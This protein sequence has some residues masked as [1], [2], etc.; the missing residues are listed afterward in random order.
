[1]IQPIIPTDYQLAGA[2][3]IAVDVQARTSKAPRKL[4]KWQR[5][6]KVKKNQIKFK[7]GK[8]NLK[9]M[10]RAYRRRNK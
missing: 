8:L 9:A 4:S 2:E 6:M 5:Y 1:V 10:G 3:V 7:N